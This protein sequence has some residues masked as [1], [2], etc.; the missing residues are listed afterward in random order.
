MQMLLDNPFINQD[1]QNNQKVLPPKNIA[2]WKICRFVGQV[3]EICI[4][5][6]G[7][8]FILMLYKMMGG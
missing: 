5:L 2:I 4:I 3:M 8:Y 6:L 1:F 7:V